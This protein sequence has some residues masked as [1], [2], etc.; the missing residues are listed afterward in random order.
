MVVG[1]A[2]NVA[3]DGGVRLALVEAVG[4]ARSVRDIDIASQD[5]RFQSPERKAWF[6]KPS[7]RRAKSYFRRMFAPTR[8]P[9]SS[10]RAGLT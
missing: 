7:R 4:D 8:A 6:M 3:L 2:A 9:S 5:Y 10:E 1:D